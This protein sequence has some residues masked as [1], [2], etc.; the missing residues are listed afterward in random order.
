MSPHNSEG[1]V[2]VHYVVTPVTSNKGTVVK[3]DRAAA[4]AIILIVIA[5]VGL[6][7][8]GL[9]YSLHAKQPANQTTPLQTNNPTTSTPNA[10]S[11]SQTAVGD[12]KT[13]KLEANSI[14]T[15]NNLTVNGP[16]TFTGITNN[17]SFEQNGASVINGTTSFKSGAVAITDSLNVSGTTTL[18]GLKAGA[19]NLTSLN[20][21]GTTTLK[22]LTV[23]SAL[24]IKGGLTVS[25]GNLSLTA[26][27]ISASG[28]INGTNLSGGTVS[29][30]NLSDSAVNG[31][32]V[33][34]GS[35]TLGTWQASP[36]GPIYG[37]T[38]LSSIAQGDLLYG[39][40]SNVISRLTVGTNGQCL[41]VATSLPSWGS[42]GGGAGSLQGAYD[43]GNTITL[44]NGTDLSVSLANTVT[45][46]NII[47][48]IASGSTGKFAV[49]NSGTDV[50]R[51]VATG[52]VV[53][54]GGLD[55]T[56]TGVTNTGALAGVTTINASST[57]TT[58]GNINQTGAT[59]LST[60]T[61]AISLNGD[62]TVASNKSLKL[63][64]GTS[65]PGSPSEGQLFFRSD[66]KQLYIYENGQWQADRSVATVV[67]AASNSQNKEKADYIATGT[68]DESPINSAINALPA[69]G[70]IVYLLDG[71]FNFGSTMTITK[72]NVSVTGAGKSTIIKKVFD[73][74]VV[75]QVGDGGTTTVTG[76]VLTNFA[77]DGNKAVE[78][79]SGDMIKF[80]KKVSDS[81][82]TNLSISN[83][84]VAI[85]LTNTAS[86]EAND[87]NLIQNNN[88]QTDSSTEGWGIA[89]QGYNRYTIIDSN[90]IRGGNSSDQ[91]IL[92]DT[93]SPYTVIS[94]NT[95]NSSG[96]QYAI[97][98][99]SDS[100]SI[101]GNVIRGG[102]RG[103]IIG[104]TNITVSG[105]SIVGS[106]DEGIYTSP[107]ANNDIITG[108]DVNT[109]GTFGI[110]LYNGSGTV[111][112]GNKVH[113]NGD[114]GIEIETSGNTVIGNDITDTAGTSKAINITAAASNNYIAN[115]RFS[116]TG[117][118]S[119]ADAG[120]GTIY[121]SQMDGSGNLVTKG[122]VFAIATNGAASSPAELLQGTWF[123]GGSATTTKPQ[124]LVEPTGTSS[125]NWST[126]GT[127]IGVNAA[128]GFTGNLI[129][130]QVAAS[131]KFKVTS[132]GDTT[133][134]GNLTVSGSGT[135]TFAGTIQVST[136][137]SSGALAVTSAANGDISVTPNGTGKVKLTVSGNASSAVIIGD[138]G[139]TNYTKFDTNGALTF[140]GTARPYGELFLLPQDALF[141]GSNTCSLSSTTTG[142]DGT[143]PIVYK[144]VDCTTTNKDAFWETKMPQ[145]Y[146][147]GTDV[148]V[149]I[150]WMANAT[151]GA[152]TWDVGYASVASGANWDGAAISNTAG[153]SVTTNGTAKYINT[154]TVTLTAPSINAN[155]IVDWRLRN[156]ANTTGQNA[157][158]IKIRLKYLVNS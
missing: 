118:S 23:S 1:A 90:Y 46:P 89:I 74:S 58:S 40:G 50:L 149:D 63:T 17:G 61:G 126:A 10:G 148:Q 111:V 35:I 96:Y 82:I 139:S 125:T 113:D 152:A 124:L 79:T 153:G 157:Q 119:I 30:G 76:I 73:A 27:S 108:N 120:T 33:A 99:I 103:I 60:G 18:A 43:G 114:N 78:T 5:L 77:I 57:F 47:F 138:G 22:S 110:A 12:I 54:S 158:I 80:N 31:L 14:T 143:N 41:T 105:N 56:S 4:W 141:P 72:S 13:N 55:L 45:D 150:Y 68:N 84:I 16:S 81:Q 71:T 42:C 130:L 95:I 102:F 28:T 136:I 70:G 146:A 147:N 38:G 101:T 154:S 3:H 15:S 128:S 156:S 151:T 7:G 11:T 36:I 142:S 134:G 94:N 88:F 145:N 97:N 140:N 112:S 83:F 87:H 26:G 49:Q 144:T 24:T 92:V 21:S 131:N 107:G 133:V 117:A 135:H 86:G 127:G 65:F 104:G 155:D 32:S 59:T 64:G 51:V 115:N 9:F 52:V 116:G 6:V 93:N 39:S 34:N 19:A 37:G 29:G 121:S 122:N 8:F 48:N 20:V 75:I 137:T 106:A 2:P 85:R 132:A 44:A 91:G 98:V 69:T 67:V 123:S 66:S 109:S 53:N 62:T 129:D 100:S 25:S